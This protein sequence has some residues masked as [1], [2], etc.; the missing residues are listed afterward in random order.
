MSSK[1][2]EFFADF[3]KSGAAKKVLKSLTSTSLTKQSGHTRLWPPKSKDA[4]WGLRIDRGQGAN[5]KDSFHLQVNQQATSDG[6]VKWVKKQGAKGTH[7]DLSRSTFDPK[8][9]NTEE[10][11]KNAMGTLQNQAVQNVKDGKPAK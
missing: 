1:L 9:K 11:L 6:L 8:A 5:G 3:W 10:E 7:A 2:N 4:T